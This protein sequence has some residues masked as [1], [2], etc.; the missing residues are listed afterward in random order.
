MQP[1]EPGDSF[2]GRQ[3]GFD[4]PPDGQAAKQDGADGDEATNGPSLAGQ[5]G[6][7]LTG[8]LPVLLE[9]RAIE[10]ALGQQ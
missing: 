9:L 10:L 8:G 2:G 4:S 7:V 1:V 3:S 5:H 6:Q